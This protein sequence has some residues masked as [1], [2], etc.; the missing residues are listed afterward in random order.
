MISIDL[1]NVRIKK[2]IHIKA[3]R[4]QLSKSFKDWQNSAINNQNITAKTVI[5]RKAFLEL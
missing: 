1:K 4:R 5:M 2:Y 3:I